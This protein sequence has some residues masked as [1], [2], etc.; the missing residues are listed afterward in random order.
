VRLPG[1]REPIQRYQYVQPR[2]DRDR[3]T[4][5]R[6]AH[7]IEP[8][9]QE[10]TR[11]QSGCT[12]DEH[13]RIAEETEQGGVQIQQ[14]RRV[15]R[16]KVAIREIAVEDARRLLEKIAFVLRVESYANECQ[17]HT[18]HEQQA[19][20]R[21]RVTSPTPPTQPTDRPGG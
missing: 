11:Y 19:C 20:D 9:G 12:Q 7:Q 14:A 8:A 4:H 17:V 13:V 5:Q 3:R 21:Q 10:H 16:I 15:Q 18:Q 1:E 2:Q 6:S